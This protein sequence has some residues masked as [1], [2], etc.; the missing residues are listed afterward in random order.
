[1]SPSREK[2]F[3]STVALELE[4]T[5]GK[6]FGL[7]PPKTWSKPAI[8]EFLETMT[9]E[10]AELCRHK[11]QNAKRCGVKENRSKS[12][13]EQLKM[14]YPTFWRRFQSSTQTNSSATYRNRF[15]IYLGAR[16][17]ENYL[18]S[19]TIEG[20]EKKDTKDI[21]FTLNQKITQKFISYKSET[22][23]GRLNEL[24]KLR[25]SI[26]EKGRI[27]T[28]LGITG[29]GKTA[30]AEKLV[31][32]IMHSEGISQ[33]SVFIEDYYKDD[34][35][36]QFE[37]FSRE[38]I[39][40]FSIELSTQIQNREQLLEVIVEHLKLNKCLL[41]INSIEYILQ[42]NIKK[43][44]NIFRD[45]LWY[46]FFLR[47]SKLN[48]FGSRLIITSQTRPDELV[49]LQDRYH[50]RISY[51][52]IRG[53]NTQDAIELFSKWSLLKSDDV[54]QKEL[55]SRIA[56]VYDGH[57]LALETIAG[58]I[59]VDFEENINKYWE[60]YN[61]EI[62][63]AEVAKK[64]GRGEVSLHD[65]SENL[66]ERVEARVENT[67]QRLKTANID[68]YNILIH[69]S[70][71]PRV[72]KSYFAGHY[73]RLLELNEQQINAAVTTLIKRFLLI[74]RGDEFEQ[75]DLI[76]SVAFRHLEQA[77]RR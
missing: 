53:L 3:W 63:D 75:H 10:L 15:A 5:Y 54:K 12:L 8:L 43:S 39:Q 71:K 31:L 60:V 29:I 58:E 9:E 44:N 47:I 73:Q 35:E 66:K 14:S 19:A 72:H 41:V 37:K 51:E 17:A 76:R 25:S 21:L 16:D 18:K 27:L 46:Q 45:N 59:K 1:M 42:L 30:L 7:G 11:P 22:W 2:K 70:F 77:K 36:T 20:A 55:V 61:K 6:K 13:V 65:W 67:L 34:S 52:L 48:S 23:V 4:Q 56:A 57:P 28:L 33:E 74:K 68:A 26:G 32:E 49:Q 64:S 38:L 62:A 24:R 40:H 69:L 50:N